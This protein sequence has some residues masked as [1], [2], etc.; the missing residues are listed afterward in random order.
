MEDRCCEQSE[1]AGISQCDHIYSRLCAA[2]FP[3]LAPA[4]AQSSETRKVARSL[5]T[6]WWQVGRLLG[7]SCITL[8]GALDQTEAELLSSQR[9]TVTASTEKHSYRVLSSLKNTMSVT[10]QPYARCHVLDNF[11]LT[12][13]TDSIWNDKY[14]AIFNLGSCQGAYDCLWWGQRNRVGWC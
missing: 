9:D 10:I 8:K 12:M 3:D 4:F 1:S 6:I 2:C 7:L 11:W 5:Q 14:S 13:W